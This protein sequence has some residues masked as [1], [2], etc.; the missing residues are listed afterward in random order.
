MIFLKK[1]LV[2][3][4]CRSFT[5]RLSASAF[6]SVVPLT[7]ALPVQRNGGGYGRGSG[8]HGSCCCRNGRRLGGVFLLQELLDLRLEVAD[9]LFQR[10]L[11]RFYSLILSKPEHTSSCG[12]WG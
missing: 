4:S 5:V 8:S 6:Y 11:G 7:E 10:H 9:G 3:F 12:R 2:F 1:A